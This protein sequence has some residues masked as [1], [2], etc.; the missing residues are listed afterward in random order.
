MWPSRSAIPFITRRVRMCASQAVAGQGPRRPRRTYGSTHGRLR[1]RE[2]RRRLLD[3]LVPRPGEPAL[4]ALLR[5]R[6][7]AVPLAARLLVVDLEPVA[8]GIREVDADRHGVVRHAD[9]YV[10]GLQSVVHLGEVLEAS[11]APG[12]VIQAH[13]LLLRAGRVLTYLEQGDVMRVVAVARQEGRPKLA[14]CRKRH[15]VLG[16]QPE[17]IRVPLVRAFGVA[18]E[19]VD[20]IEGYRLVGHGL[21]P[22]GRIDSEASIPQGGGAPG[23]GQFAKISIR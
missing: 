17:D 2:R 12:H 21:S 10:L 23:W 15:G 19:D 22:A 8:V 9:G 11:H 16:M 7:L 6:P 20:M 18:H 1:P 5:E 3:H 14:G 4:R 13:A